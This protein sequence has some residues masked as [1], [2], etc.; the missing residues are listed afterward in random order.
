[1]GWKREKVKEEMEENKTRMRGRKTNI[2]ENTREK[3]AEKLLLSLFKHEMEET[4]LTSPLL[5]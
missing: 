5:L 1:M 4:H 3:S 2:L